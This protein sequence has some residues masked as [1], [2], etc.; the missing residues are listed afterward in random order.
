M[1][2][3]SPSD[4]VRVLLAGGRGRRLGG[5][6]KALV[7]L[8]GRPMAARVLARAG[9]DCRATVLNANGDAARF[10]AL[11]LPVAEDVV[12][13]AAGP[14]AGLLT[15][16]EWAAAHEPACTH[17]LTLPTDAPFLPRDLL[18]RLADAL[19]DG[20]EIARASSGGRS[21]H[22]VALWPVALRG[23][24]RRAVEAEGARKVQA[25]TAAY[26]VAE[27]DW[28]VGE[29]DPF[30]NVN[31]PEDVTEALRLTRA[32]AAAARTGSPP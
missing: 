7:D 26:R 20:A 8:D 31:T 19:G 13:G 21:H 2:R 5:R 22:V 16:L 32:A 9:G 15:G 1:A 25:W 29:T 24:L 28:P 17:V 30:F 4:V 6:D 3:P 18:E 10:A 11:G 23:A 12:P 27:V 14:L